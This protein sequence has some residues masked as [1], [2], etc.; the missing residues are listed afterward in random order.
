MGIFGSVKDAFSGGA[1]GKLKSL[2]QDIVNLS[3]N[4]QRRNY[5]SKDAVRKAAEDLIAKHSGDELR[6]EEAAFATVYGL[7][8]RLQKSSS[9]IHGEQDEETLRYYDGVMRAVLELAQEYD[10]ARL[11]ASHRPHVIAY[12]LYYLDLEVY[13]SA[14]KHRVSRAKR[15]RKAKKKGD[16]KEMQKLEQLIE[17]ELKE[18]MGKYLDTLE[19]QVEKIEQRLNSPQ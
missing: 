4:I 9:E 10:T 13:S 11:R 8:A 16:K 15:Y 5:S 14:N 12:A 1:Q 7:A 2:D 3:L 18:E 17:D 6:T 19:T